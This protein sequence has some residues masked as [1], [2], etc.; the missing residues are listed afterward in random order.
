MKRAARLL[1]VALFGLT[2]C[3]SDNTDTLTVSAAASLTDAVTALLR[4]RDEELLKAL[5]QERGVAKR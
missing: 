3:S 2:A 4:I 5:G 1:V